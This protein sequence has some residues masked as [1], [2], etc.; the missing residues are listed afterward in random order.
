MP[1]IAHQGKNP[2]QRDIVAMQELGLG[3]L[4]RRA[5][6]SKPKPTAMIILR[7]IV[8]INN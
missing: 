5:T 4:H 7:I 3:Q 1:G 2:S 6:I 8:F